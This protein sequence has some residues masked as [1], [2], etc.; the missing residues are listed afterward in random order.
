MHNS[1]SGNNR[2]GNHKS[3]WQQGLSR[4]YLWNDEYAGKPFDVLIV[5]GGI[6]GITTA[7]MLQGQGRNCILVDAHNIGF[8]TTGG[9]SAHINTFADTSYAEAESAFGQEGAQLFAQAINEGFSIIQ[10]NVNTLG[11]D[12]DYE[13]KEGY[14]YAE[15]EQQMKELQQIYE[16][17]VKYNI[18]VNFTKD[19]PV[20]VAFKEALIFPGQAQ[21][22]PTKYIQ[23]L[24]DAYVAKGGIIV[25]HFI[26]DEVARDGDYYRVACNG[27]AI[28]AKKVVYATH[29]PPG[30]N[31]FSARCAPYRSY[32]LGVS[33]A[34]KNYP[35]AL[36]Y[37]MQDPYHYFRTHTIRRKKYLIVGGNDHKTGHD[38]PG[39]AFNDLEKYVREHYQ[40]S[41]VAFRWSSQYYVPVDG[42]P[43]IGLMPG[44]SEIY[45]ATGYNGNGMML[46]S[47][48]AKIIADAI[49]GKQNKYRKIFD[50]SRMK[51]IAGFKEFV[52]E[53]ADVVY[54][55]VTSQFS[56]AEIDSVKNIPKDTGRVVELQGKRLAIFKD[57]DGETHILSPV[58]THAGC[59]VNWNDQEKSWDCPCHGARYDI[60]GN[61]LNGPTKK[62]LDKIDIGEI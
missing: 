48:A 15:N 60:D 38:D 61:V 42:F 20:P 13:I 62:N 3:P 23:A 12:C 22:H 17:S 10:A 55:L 30:I 39:Q 59:I 26:V 9:T 36:A 44:E 34:D 50:P 49:L 57:R 27:N 5:G 54:Q 6:T 1:L 21:F 52:K 33:L 29:V 37:D 25:E 18:A 47:V 24:A 43:Y 4:N 7:L 35:D 28:Q 56:A 58:C 16:A 14:L 32:V 46:G 2:D 8:G 19:I 53:N 40:V 45:C 51:P 11:I 41:E 31:I